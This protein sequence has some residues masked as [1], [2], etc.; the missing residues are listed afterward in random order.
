MK[1]MFPLHPVNSPPQDS[2]LSRNGSRPS[3]SKTMKTTTTS[4]SQSTEQNSHQHDDLGDTSWINTQQT[5]TES[6]KLLQPASNNRNK[7]NDKMTKKG[8]SLSISRDSDSGASLEQFL[9][10]KPSKTECTPNF[11]HKTTDDERLL[12]DRQHP[13]QLSALSRSVGQ[14]SPT[15]ISKELRENS[16]SIPELSKISEMLGITCT[17]GFCIE[18]WSKAKKN[19]NNKDCAAQPISKK[20]TTVKQRYN[21]YSHGLKTKTEISSAGPCLEPKEKQSLE[22]VN[23]NSPSHSHQNLG[24]PLLK[25]SSRSSIAKSKK[26]SKSSVGAKSSMDNIV[27]IEKKQTEQQERKMERINSR[28]D[29][30]TEHSPPSKTRCSD[31]CESEPTTHPPSSS[32]PLPHKDSVEF[33]IEQ[34][35]QSKLEKQSTLDQMT[36]FSSNLELELSF[37][38]SPHV[39]DAH[40]L[41]TPKHH[42]NDD[43]HT[44][45]E[46]ENSSHHELNK[47]NDSQKDSSSSF[48][49]SSF[50]SQSQIDSFALVKNDSFTK[51]SSSLLFDE[52]DNV[53]RAYAS[54]AN[55]I[56]EKNEQESGT[57]SL[58]HSEETS[59]SHSEK[60]NIIEG[61]STVEPS[62]KEIEKEKKE[63][64]EENVSIDITP[65]QQL[66]S[67][68]KRTDEPGSLSTIEVASRTSQKSSFLNSG[69]Q[70]TMKEI[71][72]TKNK[73]FAWGTKDSL[74]RKVP[75]VTANLLQ[76]SENF[77]LHYSF[78]FVFTFP[79]G[80]RNFS[81]FV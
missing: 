52:S 20:E 35:N 46:S 70:K 39:T 42:D 15:K 4:S 75:L 69:K 13:Q 19:S 11:E 47:Q 9:E 77:V 23:H 81:F 45:N 51:L 6:Q 65:S 58:S 56:N 16:S 31:H 71:S 33:P 43:D 2:T 57:S 72:E 41:E 79:P 37:G 30:I 62:E 59:H 14:N 44:K 7:E 76:N 68:T 26:G 78:H 74:H 18:P 54:A 17:K 10:K 24:N 48:L 12:F 40:S 53:S 63:K 38:N 25:A 64:K 67:I 3:I 55:T 5:H 80:I 36:A 61:H 66:Q 22:T 8:S 60:E 29:I 73:S 1:P 50:S 27:P 32:S 34:P 21:A 49:D 28:N